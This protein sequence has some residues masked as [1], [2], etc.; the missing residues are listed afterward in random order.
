MSSYLKKVTKSR[1]AFRKKLSSKSIG[2]KSTLLDRLIII[3]TGA[4]TIRDVVLFPQL[5]R[6]D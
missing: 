1:E 4:P 3:L 5:K 2:E 6:K